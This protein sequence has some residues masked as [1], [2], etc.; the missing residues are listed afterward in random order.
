MTELLFLLLPIA[1]AS[2]WYAARRSYKKDPN[3]QRDRFAR[4]YLVGLNYLLNEQPDKAVDMFVK[5]LEVDSETVETHLA[6]GVLFRRRGEVDRAI[7]IHQ[8]LIA[9]PQL[10]KQQRAQALLALAQDYNRAG[11]LDRAEKMFLEV[12]E[13]SSEYSSYALRYLLDIYQQQKRW[14]TA[15][16]T[17]K[18]LLSADQDVAKKIAHYYCELADEHLQ[19]NNV[20]QA[21]RVLKQ[22]L[23]A[24]SACVRASILLGNIALK[25]E[26]IPAAIE[27]YQKVKL[28]DADY[29]SETIK[30]LIQCYTQL[31]NG[32][33][34]LSD[35]L[36][37][38]LTEYPRAST[39]L[40]LVELIQNKAGYDA[41][42]QF[43]IQNLQRRPS[44]RGLQRLIALQHDNVEHGSREH[45][46]VLQLLIGNLLKSKPIYRCVTCG[47]GS[48]I[49]HWL[50]PGCR[51]WST[52]KPVQGIEG[53]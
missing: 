20:D 14:D 2:G 51:N 27:N 38:L 37:S 46:S 49:L 13:F 26:K 24:D 22:A 50:C 48:K 21:Q 11:V 7:R 15:I 35:Y 52:V 17:A 31:D 23:S 16:V 44:L 47:F 12:V 40:A 3:Y 9:R 53:E 6:L 8:N 29:I 45:L 5:M 32:Q 10:P 41:V 34:K 42:T 43:L 4:D 39:L 19:K 28:Q 18:K 30:P 1:A 36:S 25:A 33:E